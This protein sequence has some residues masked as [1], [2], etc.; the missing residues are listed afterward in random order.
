MVKDAQDALTWCLLPDFDL[1]AKRPLV[2]RSVRTLI[3]PALRPES[4][5]RFI[6]TEHAVADNV[7]FA[8]RAENEERVLHPIFGDSASRISI[9]GLGDR[10][11]REAGMRAEPTLD[12]ITSTASR[13]GR[14]DLHYGWRTA[15]LTTE[16]HRLRYSRFD[17]TKFRCVLVPR[18]SHPYFRALIEA[19]S[20]QGVPTVYVPHSPLTYRQVDLP[21]SHAGLRGQAERDFIATAA[22]ADPARM[23]II[24]NPGSDLLGRGLP[25]LDLAR[26]GVLALAPDSTPRLERTIRLVHGAGLGDVVVAPH[27]RTDLP[28]LRK[29]I[30]KSWSVHTGSRTS[31]LLRQGPPWLIQSN[32]GIAWESAALGIPTANL[33]LGDGIPTYPFLEQPLIPKIDSSDEVRAFVESAVYTDRIALRET[34]LSWCGFDGEQAQRAAQRFLDDVSAT[35]PIDRIAD[36]W[37]PDGALWKQSSLTA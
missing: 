24:G 18:Q 20:A 21:V 22:S 35:D 25:A 16:W 29:L 34:M 36:A 13:L 17:L 14:L 28:A 23:T 32:S 4:K 33:Q 15:A 12:W 5:R 6:P 3:R 19:A 7:L 31:D 26:P 37:A 8:W 1:Q 27:P 30:P 2:R 11:S 10:V 9:P